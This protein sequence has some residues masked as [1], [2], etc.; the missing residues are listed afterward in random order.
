M[1]ADREIRSMRAK[2][3]ISLMTSDDKLIDIL[4]FRLDVIS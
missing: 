4:T 1:K 2:R 3:S